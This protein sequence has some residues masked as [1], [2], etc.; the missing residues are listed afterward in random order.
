MQKTID[1]S[2][3]PPKIRP[4]PN[5]ISRGSSSPILESSQNRLHP[6]AQV[7]VFNSLQKLNTIS[8]IDDSLVVDF[9]LEKF[10]GLRFS[11]R[12]KISL[13]FEHTFPYFVQS[14][15]VPIFAIIYYSIFDLKI[16]GRENL[17]NT[18]G[19][20]LFVSNHI[21]FYDSF[22]FDLFVHPFSHILP[23]R[24]MGSRVFIV[25]FLAVLKLIG[26]VDLVYFLF[27]VFRVTP[28]EG[29][30]K[31]LKHAY[32]IIKRGGTVAMYPEGRIWH[33]TNVHPEEIGPFKWGAA[34]LAR[35]TGVQVIP[36]AMKRTYIKNGWRTK[37]EVNIG[38]PFHVDTYKTPEVLADE[39]RER[40]VR[41]YEER[42]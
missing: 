17:I 24:F 32:E 35:N 42:K 30:E 11:V 6:V 34:I 12:K 38:K 25:P 9:S 13:F 2:N 22:I 36:V 8:G 26:I 29:A 3:K 31:S 5:I 20:M 18:R 7:P 4:R 40:V 1:T 10:N 19:P 41:L 33:P 21:S 14:M 28:G 39:M 16:N 15:F 27:G 37:I 23:F